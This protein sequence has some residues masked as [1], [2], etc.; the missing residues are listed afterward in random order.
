M[1][2]QN[3]IQSC[4][5]KFWDVVTPVLGHQGAIVKFNSFI[6]SLRLDKT[7]YLFFL[8]AVC[9]SVGFVAGLLIGKIIE[10]TTLV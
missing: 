5:M 7:R 8:I 6:S 2:F 4:E 1:S 10:I 3:F 9:G